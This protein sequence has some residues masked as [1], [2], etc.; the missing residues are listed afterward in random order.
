VRHVAVCRVVR[1]GSDLR[2]GALIR[3]TFTVWLT[4][5][6]ACWEDPKIL[7]HL[8]S[9]LPPSLALTPDP[10]AFF[11]PSTAADADADAA[12]QS[13][14]DPYSTPAPSQGDHGIGRHNTRHM[15]HEQY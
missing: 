10:P 7:S 6:E 12:K 14:T 4:R 8:P 11:R 1:V 9:T 2:L 3:F 13:C 15:R 5:D